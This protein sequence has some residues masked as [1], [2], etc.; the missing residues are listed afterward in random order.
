MKL[1]IRVEFVY[2]PIP[3]RQFDWSAALDGYEP[4]DPL[5]YGP[6][7]WEAVRDLIDQ[8][9]DR[10]ENGDPPPSPPYDTLEEKKQSLG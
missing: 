4:G 5:G 8:L 7:K 10:D 2:P 1:K 9:E 6:T 3:Q